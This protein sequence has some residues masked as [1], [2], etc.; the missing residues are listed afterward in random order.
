MMGPTKEAVLQVLQEHQGEDQGVTIAGLVERFYGLRY[1]ENRGRA[2]AQRDL[3]LAIEALRCEG[4]RIC[5]TPETGYFMA[6]TD[7]ELDGTCG[8]LYTR[9]M[10]SLKQ[11]AAMKRVALPDLRGQLRLPL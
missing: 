7:A 6:T 1:Y 11:V 5:A 2:G 3:R 9:A 10:T 4:H 8:F